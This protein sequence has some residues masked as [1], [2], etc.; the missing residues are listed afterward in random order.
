MVSRGLTI[1]RY[2]HRVGLDEAISGVDTTKLAG[3]RSVSYNRIASRNHPVKAFYG[4]TFLTQQQ[5]P[6]MSQ[7]CCS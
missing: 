4:K 2:W 7:I 6:V 3:S 1:F 5:L